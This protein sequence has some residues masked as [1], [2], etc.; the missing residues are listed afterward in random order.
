MSHSPHSRPRGI[1]TVLMYSGDPPSMPLVVTRHASKRMQ[2]RAISPSAIDLVLR[3]GREYHAG[4]GA[5]AYHLGR[6]VVK[7][8]RSEGLRIEVAEHICVVFSADGAIMTVQ[9]MRQIPR[10]WRA[11]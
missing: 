9:H 6:R 1:P 8:A 11:A 4:D 10:S 2:Q 5:V 3:H 7:G